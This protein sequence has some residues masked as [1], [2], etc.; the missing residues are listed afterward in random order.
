MQGS[1]GSA[2]A[3]LRSGT[4]ILGEIGFDERL[5]QYHHDTLN[6]S[7]MPY[8]PMDKV[9]ELFLRLELQVNQVSLNNC[10]PE[11]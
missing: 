1:Y 11:R 4:K 6:A 10:H 9:E 3:H 2:I 8:V 7:L 5:N